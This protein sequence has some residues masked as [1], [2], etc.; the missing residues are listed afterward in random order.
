LIKEMF[1]LWIILF[2]VICFFLYT[3]LSI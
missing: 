2:I 1:N 3:Q